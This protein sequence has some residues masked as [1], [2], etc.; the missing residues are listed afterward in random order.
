MCRQIPRKAMEERLSKGAVKELLVRTEVDLKTAKKWLAA[1][2]LMVTGGD[3]DCLDIQ[4]HD[5]ATEMIVES[6]RVINRVTELAEKWQALALE[7]FEVDTKVVQWIIQV[8]KVKTELRMMLSMFKAAESIRQG[9]KDPLQWILEEV[10]TSKM[11][12]GWKETMT[13]KSLRLLEKESVAQP[14]PKSQVRKACEEYKAAE[15]E[16]EIANRQ[17]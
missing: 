6:S 14:K 2:N 4:D 3:P 17:L 1:R 5:V 11:E 10:Q 12:E 9:E 8:T 15:A 16:A 13:P 7:P